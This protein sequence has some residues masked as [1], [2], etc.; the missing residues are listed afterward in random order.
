MSRINEVSE[1]ALIQRINRKLEST[2]SWDRIRTSRSAQDRQ[3]IGKYYKLDLYHN[4]VIDTYV[5]LE[6]VARDL[7]V[8]H[9]LERISDMNGNQK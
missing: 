2:G 7:E 1:Q 4:L 3:N 8:M 9:P 6:R 5:D